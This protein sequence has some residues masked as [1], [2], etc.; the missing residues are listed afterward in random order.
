MAGGVLLAFASTLA[1]AAYQHFWELQP[2]FPLTSPPVLL[3][4]TGGLGIVAG[5]GGLLAL[6]TRM[7]REV[8]E[9]GETQLNVIFLVALQLVTLSGL[10]LLFFRDTSAMGPLLLGHLSLVTGFFLAL[11]A[12]KALHAPFRAAA[13]LRYALTPRPKTRT[14]APD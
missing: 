14:V 11:P 7:E 3:G 5:A 13:L 2:P 12:T 10:A 8:S 6:E 9:P 4:L 1:A